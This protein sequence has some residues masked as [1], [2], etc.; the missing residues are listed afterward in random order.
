DPS[1]IEAWDWATYDVVLNAAAYTSVDAAEMPDGRPLAWA[2][3]AAAPSHLARLSRRH[4]FTLVHVSSD[5]VFD[6]SKSEYDETAPFSPLGVYGQS[7]AAGDLA[8]ATAPR[9]YIVRTSW[10]VGSG[11]NFVKTMAKLA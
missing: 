8:V 3:N 5:Y 4:R 6:G 1:A 2:V 9:H 7:K 10:V 11:P